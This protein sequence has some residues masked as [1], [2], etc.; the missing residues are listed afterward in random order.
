M[1]MGN[2]GRVDAGLRTNTKNPA[3]GNDGFGT[4]YVH[5]SDNARRGSASIEQAGKSGVA[6]FYM[7]S[8]TVQTG[9]NEHVF[10]RFFPGG[11]AAAR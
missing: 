6:Y 2:L 5:H 7:Q 1:M 9:V 4:T 8:C 3:A 11:K 10:G